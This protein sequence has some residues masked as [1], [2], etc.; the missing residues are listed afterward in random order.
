MLIQVIA[1]S[2]VTL[3][4]LHLG[5][6]ARNVIFTVQLHFRQVAVPCAA[7]E[8]PDIPVGAGVLDLIRVDI[9]PRIVR[10]TRY[11]RCQVRPR[12]IVR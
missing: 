1:Q 11:G 5:L 7:V 8:D 2:G 9:R 12:G 4:P 6:D 10:S 3:R